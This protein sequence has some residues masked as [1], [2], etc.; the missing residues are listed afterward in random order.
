[1]GMGTSVWKLGKTMRRCVTF[2]V[3]VGML[4]LMATGAWGTPSP[5]PPAAVSLDVHIVLDAK[6]NQV[7]EE[8]DAYLHSVLPDDEVHLRTIDVPHVTLYLTSFLAKDVGTVVAKAGEVV[9]GFGSCASYLNATVV[10]GAYGMWTGPPVPCLQAMSDALVRALVPYIGPVSVPA[11]VNN[12]PP[13]ER[14]EKIKLIHEYGSPNVFQGFQPHVTLAWDNSTSP[15]TFGS[16]LDALGLNGVVTDYHPSAIAI[17]HTGPHGT[18]LRNGTIAQF[19][20]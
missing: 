4:V 13:K 10:S 14:E 12:L 6:T 19:P 3:V 11:W 15:T 18:V 1:M 17:S 2:A 8:A 16:A 9:A 20:L 7:A 5:P